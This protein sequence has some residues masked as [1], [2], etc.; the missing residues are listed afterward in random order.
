MLPQ[1]L[2]VGIDQGSVRGL[3]ADVQLA[4]PG[5]PG[6]WADFTRVTAPKTDPYG[7]GVLQRFG[8]SVAFTMREKDSG[9][10]VLVSQQDNAGVVGYGFD[11]AGRQRQVEHRRF[12]DDQGIDRQPVAGVVTEAAAGGHHAEKPVDDGSRPTLLSNFEP[13]ERVPV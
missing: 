9:K 12:I 7:W 1:A 5:L 10:L 6:E 8:L 3:Y 4:P 2:Q 11:Q 13:S